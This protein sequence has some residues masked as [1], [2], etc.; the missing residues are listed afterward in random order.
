MRIYY[1]LTIAMYANDGTPK[2]GQNVRYLGSEHSPLFPLRVLYAPQIEGAV[3]AGTPEQPFPPDDGIPTMF[4]D[5]NVPFNFS[6]AGGEPMKLKAAAANYL[7]CLQTI[8]QRAPSVPVG[9]YGVLPDAPDQLATY[10]QTL[11][12]ARTPIVNFSDWLCIDTG[13]LVS[14]AQFDTQLG[15]SDGVKAAFPRQKLVALVRPHKLTDAEFRRRM[16]A[17]A[18]KPGIDGVFVWMSGED[19]MEDLAPSYPQIAR[20]IALKYPGGKPLKA[21]GME[22]VLNHLMDEIQKGA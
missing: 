13:D 14:A 9:A 10:G 19:K 12:D 15:W 6:A 7:A 22:R 2:V 3:M 11:I 4:D 20:E 5:E 21:G 1:D 16:E 17:A 8:R 18:T